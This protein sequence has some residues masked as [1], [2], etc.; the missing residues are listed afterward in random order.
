MKQRWLLL[1]AALGLMALF[2]TGCKQETNENNTTAATE[3]SSTDTITTT[4]TMSATDS[5]NTGLSSTAGTSTSSTA[6]N[7]GTANGTTSSLSAEDKEFMTKAAIGGMAEVMMG[8]M[9]STKATDAGVK[10]FG[11]RMVTD[12]S[13]AND[14]LKSLAAQK[15]MVLPTDVDA[16]HK[17]KSDKMS[18]KSGKDFDKAY[19]ADMVEDHEKDVSEFQKASQNAADP[20]LKAWATKTLPTLQDH[21]KMAKDT[22]AK[23]K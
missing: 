18:Q 11:N 16:E 22:K 12:H 13:K 15:G 14:E 10:T 8:Q 9:A 17:E 6:A 23:L 20:D 5:T 21:L 19:M 2:V 7:T 1:L 3:T 4:S